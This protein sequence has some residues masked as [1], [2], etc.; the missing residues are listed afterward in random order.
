M[1]S[2]HAHPQPPAEDLSK[3][4]HERYHA[5]SHFKDREHEFD[6]VKMGVWLFLATEI[7]LFSGMFCAYFIFRMMHPEAF[8]GGG[9]HLEVKWGL[10]NTIVLLM[11]SYWVAAGVRHAQT[12]NQ[13]W[14]QINIVLTFLAGLAFLV[15][16]FVFEY[17]HKIEVG[18][19]PG[20][21]YHYA[22]KADAYEPLWW[23]VYWGATGIHASHVIVGMG[24]FAWLFV[25]SRKGHFG[26]GHYNAV[27]GVGLYWHIVD[28][29][30]IFL[31][32]LL[33]LIH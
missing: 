22:D 2:I 4:L 30:W 26:P 27:E 3:P 8:I 11:S 28:I 6:S 21:F 23:A 14:L 31:F 25:R 9:H 20:R 15:I 7:L 18:L 32:P 24:L 1:A 29:V 12:G 13:K 10:I 19:L 33:Y 17:W 16:K 5:A